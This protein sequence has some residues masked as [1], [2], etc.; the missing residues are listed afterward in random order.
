MAEVRKFTFDIDFSDPAPILS[1]SG[2][3]LVVEEVKEP[4]APPPPTFSEEELAEAREA[5]FNQGKE[6]GVR[7]TEAAT[8]RMI[9]NTLNVIAAGLQALVKAQ[10]DANEETFRSAVEV[11]VA[12]TGKI[13]PETVKRH[14]AMEIEALVGKIMP[15]LLDQ[16]RIIVRAH[17]LMVAGMKEKLEELAD[18]NGFEGR[19]VVMPD[20][21]I[22]AGD[23]RLE[24]ADGGAERSAERTWTEIEN[25][26]RTHIEASE[27]VFEPPSTPDATPDDAASDSYEPPT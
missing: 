9:A 2:T 14:G 19:V 24:W 11:A 23:C 3:P 17:S 12:V 27:R 1:V 8:E 4:S 22:P 18:A 7:E 6:D 16:P 21:K 25:I 10:E 15:H 26:V 20:D 5:S 13:L